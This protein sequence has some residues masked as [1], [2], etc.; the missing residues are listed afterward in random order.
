MCVC[1]CV[2]VGVQAQKKDGNAND[3]NAND[4][5]AM[6]E[7]LA[8]KLLLQLAAGIVKTVVN[9]VQRSSGKL[10]TTKQW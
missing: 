2:C 3:G 10:S 7:P 5:N 8:L 6:P 9:L 1:V 4:V